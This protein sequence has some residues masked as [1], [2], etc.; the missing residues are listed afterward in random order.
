MTSTYHGRPQ[1]RNNIGLSG[2]LGLPLLDWRDP[3]SAKAPY[4]VGLTP[5]GRVV[6]QRTQRPV[7]TCNFLATIAGLGQEHDNAR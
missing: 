7:S 3:A 2:F 4:P 1:R 5:G 6:F